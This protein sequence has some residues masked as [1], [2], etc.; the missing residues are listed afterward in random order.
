M[1]RP[2]NGGFQRFLSRAM[3]LYVPLSKGTRVCSRGAA[4]SQTTVGKTW[5]SSLA[6]GHNRPV[7]SQRK[8]QGCPQR[9]SNP[10]LIKYADA[11]AA[12]R[13][14]A[15]RATGRDRQP[16][17]DQP[18]SRFGVQ[19]RRDVGHRTA[20][21]TGR[22]LKLPSWKKACFSTACADAPRPDGELFA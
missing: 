14:A 7:E 22:V 12:V 13:A 9:P 16:E 5:F 3:S 20:P 15:P 17:R 21:W 2:V 11:A 18:S 6:A 8:K 10:R 1:Y 4:L 19:E